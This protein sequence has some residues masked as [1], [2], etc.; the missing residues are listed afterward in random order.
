MKYLGIYQFSKWNP[1]KI[2]NYLTN[3]YQ[4]GIWM[5]LARVQNGYKAGIASAQLGP[6]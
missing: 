6:E 5:L 4:C 3:M 1:Q 2:I